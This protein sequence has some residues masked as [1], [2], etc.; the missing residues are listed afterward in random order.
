MKIK[1]GDC[2]GN[3]E[4]EDHDTGGGDWA[5]DPPSLSEGPDKGPLRSPS[6]IRRRI[7]TRLYALRHEKKKI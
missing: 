5:S 6:W 3:S 4:K 1:K 2:G 7:G